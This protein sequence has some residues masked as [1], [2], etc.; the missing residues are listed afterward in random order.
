MK[1]IVLAGGNGSRLYPLTHAISKQLLPVYNK[2]L[3]YYPLSVLMLAG[4]RE[5]LIILTPRDLPLVRNLLG[6]GTPLGL[7]ISYMEQPNPGGIAQAFLIGSKWLADNPVCLILGDNIFYGH[8]LTPLLANSTALHQGAHVFAYQVQDPARY[9]IASF[10]QTGNAVSIEEKPVN[11]KSNW[12]LTGL[13]FYDSNAV[14]LARQLK[15]SARGELEITDLNLRYLERK[16]LKVTKLGRGVAWFDTGTYDSLLSSSL[17]VQAIEERQGLKVACLE[18]IAY[19][20]GFINAGQLAKQV[21]FNAGSDYG[22]Y[23]RKI[24][25]ESAAKPIGVSER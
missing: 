10:D 20:K 23:L 4:I 5:I 24:L 9:G 21:E 18:E 13:Y 1:G 19:F 11:P 22:Q 17:F 3:I 14:E 16:Q 2:P 8:D 12:A 6:D 7:S 15:P 25:D